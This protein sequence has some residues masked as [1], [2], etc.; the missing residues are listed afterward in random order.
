MT[1]LQ[2]AQSARGGSFTICAA[3]GT[4]L[5]F[6]GDLT[7][8]SFSARVPV[9][10]EWAAG[11]VPLHVPRLVGSMRRYTSA[12]IS[13]GSHPGAL[14]LVAAH[15]RPTTCAR[16]ASTPLNRAHLPPPP[17]PRQPRLLAQRSADSPHKH[18]DHRGPSNTDER[19]SPRS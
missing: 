18:D 13:A 15:G 2:N 16:P 4:T 11:R 7:A 1:A 3:A 19:A 10:G 8:S 17:T 9:P 14:L 6:V 12:L 5:V